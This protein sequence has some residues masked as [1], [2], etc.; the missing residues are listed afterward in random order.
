M[1]EDKQKPMHWK[2]LE[3]TFEEKQ[4]IILFLG[5]GVNFCRGRNDLDFSWDAIINYLLRYA[6][7]SIIHN[8]EDE[9]AELLA[10]SAKK[11]ID[12]C[13]VNNKLD[14]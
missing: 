6:I 13:K 9:E 7:S 5:T 12:E 11:M 8:G 2:E 3:K 1:S 10:G 4:S 14:H